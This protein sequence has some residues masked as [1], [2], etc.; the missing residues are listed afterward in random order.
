MAPVPTDAPPTGRDTPTQLASGR[1]SVERSSIRPPTLDEKESPRF[2]PAILLKPKGD[3]SW[4]LASPGEA[5][6]GPDSPEP[7]AAGENLLENLLSPPLESLAAA[8]ADEH[9]DSADEAGDVVISSD[10]LA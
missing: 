5:K 4:G 6:D 8:D 3:A 7:A 2:G 10:E 9:F 1:R